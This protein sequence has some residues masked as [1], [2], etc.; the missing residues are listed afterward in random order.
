MCP[1][2]LEKTNGIWSKQV[3][4]SILRWAFLGNETFKLFMVYRCWWGSPPQPCCG[5]CFVTADVWNTT[6]SIS[7]CSPTPPFPKAFTKWGN[8]TPW[9]GRWM[10]CS[11][12]V[13]FH[14]TGSRL[15]KFGLGP[16]GHLWAVF[17]GHHSFGQTVPWTSLKKNICVR[18]FTESFCFWIFQADGRIFETGTQTE[19]SEW[20]SW[21]RILSIDSL[22]DSF[23]KNHQ[24]PQLPEIRFTTVNSRSFWDPWRLGEATEQLSCSVGQ[25]LG[26]AKTGGG[27]LG[28]LRDGLCLEMFE[29]YTSIQIGRGK[30]N[31]DFLPNF[32]DTW[33]FL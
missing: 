11:G 24:K 4:S 30:Y 2:P 10:F 6:T 8:N 7:G 28:P 33:V 31:K 29:K 14:S 12:D 23:K 26:G 18:S 19:I 27:R 17:F 22:L 1:W 25:T 16:S 32:A 9:D 15:T 5:T 3:T 13:G 20:I 21:E